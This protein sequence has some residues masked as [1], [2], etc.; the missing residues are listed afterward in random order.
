MISDDPTRGQLQSPRQS[1][2]RIPSFL[3]AMKD[4]LWTRGWSSPV[5]LLAIMIGGIALAEV[6]AM[7]VVFFVR[8]WPYSLQILLDTRQREGEKLQTMLLDRCTAAS[9]QVD[10]IREKLPEI[11]Q[12]IRE[13]YAKKAKELSR[14]VARKKERS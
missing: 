4:V 11:T 10:Q 12:K 7:I 9:Q 6:I 1:S 8:D 13:R 5:G 2:R 3:R 14:A